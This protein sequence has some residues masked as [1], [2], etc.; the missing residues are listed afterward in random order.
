MTK[1]EWVRNEDGT[2]GLLDREPGVHE[3]DAH[4]DDA[5]TA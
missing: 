2:P 4:R 3:L 1:I 5:A